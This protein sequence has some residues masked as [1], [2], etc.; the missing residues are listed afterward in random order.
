[1]AMPVDYENSSIDLRDLGAQ[2]WQ[3]RFRIVIV[4]VLSCALA[5]LLLSFVPKTYESS[6]SILV[7]SR[8]NTF[9]RA[10]NDTGPGQT[11]VS[12]A[13]IMSS[14]VELIQSSENF[15]RV[16]RD[17]NLVEVEEF[18]G[19][20]KSP[21]DSLFA[22]IGRPPERTQGSEQKV[23]ANLSRA[24]TV[25]QQRD[26][27]VISV[28]VRAQDKNLAADIAN[29][30]AE[31][32]VTRRAELSTDDTAGASV[33]LQ[34]EIEK[35]RVNVVEAESAVAKF[36]VENDLFTGANNTSLLDQQLSNIAAQI[37][38]A[39][40]RKL[41]ASSRATLIRDL[42]NSGQS[43]DG[44]AEVQNSVVIQR[45]T[46][47]KARL[48]GEKAQLLATLL[49]NHPQVRSI[50]AQIEE[51]NKQI[52][53]EGRSVA[54]AI[55]AEARIE[56]AL[57]ASLQEDMAR[58]KLSASNAATSSVELQELE[59]EAGAQS[60]LLQTYLLRYREAT[61][62]A[63]TGAVLPDVRVI[64]VAMPALKPV[65]PKSSLILV[66]VAIVALSVQVGG[67]LFAELSAVP[68]VQ[69]RG[70]GALKEE[71]EPEVG[72][73][74]EPEA[75]YETE[76]G[77]VREPDPDSDPDLQNHDMSSSP[78]EEAD[79][80]TR[81]GDNEGVAQ[82]QSTQ[83]FAPV[84]SVSENDRHQTHNPAPSSAEAESED[85]QLEEADADFYN[86]AE[87]LCTGK[88]QLVY[89]VSFDSRG[90]CIGVGEMLI[91]ETLAAGKT[92]AIV[93]A[94]SGVTSSH[95]GIS[96]L[97]ADRVDFGEVVFPSEEGGI[98]EVYWGTER[99]IYADSDKPVILVEALC[100]ICDVVVVFA[101]EVGA[102]STLP[103]FTGLQGRV[104]LVT[105][106]QPEN[107]AA[108]RA[109]ED[110]AALGFA[111]TSLL[112]MAKNH[113]NAA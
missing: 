67:I 102:G 8:E 68:P 69:S 42:L 18:N 55:M 70:G 95:P 61:A 33:W 4:T 12:D 45:L 110:V 6:A 53:R 2:L 64:A 83:N 76:H 27:R 1:M 86:L 30:I 17:L 77:F 66:A 59:R 10:T 31:A 111:R 82:T 78:S 57:V 28:L 40:E 54:D 35:L 16:I 79:L 103:L 91:S 44:V 88:E 105:G 100:D 7:E 11:A 107:I 9:S 93:D 74:G 112:V 96:D 48:Q 89:L 99:Q 5:Y 50:S 47:D 36:R 39:Q 65:A 25:I 58:L 15:L 21:L 73:A 85:L 24:V 19:T 38:T 80:Q 94:G 34:S 20:A 113:A 14:Q 87:A 108:H 49:P 37:S 52:L 29:A 92:V 56:D 41:T 46:Q 32:H 23:L 43:I 13:V 71:Y 106:E 90:D 81:S 75:A 109:L 97:A 3:R 84:H 101:G 72:Y 98:T 104:A 62:R 26:S 22:L 60:A 63:G 51:I